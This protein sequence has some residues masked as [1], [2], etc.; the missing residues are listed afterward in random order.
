MQT[1]QLL[2]AITSISAQLLVF[3]AILHVLQKHIRSSVARESLW[4]TA[5]ILNCIS[6]LAVFAIPHLRL[7][8]EEPVDSLLIATDTAAFNRLGTAILIIWLTGM[9][10]TFGKLSLS[11]ASAARFV[12]RSSPADISR[13]GLAELWHEEI[14]KTPVPGRHAP[15]LLSSPHSTGPACW[16]FHKPVIILPPAILTYCPLPELRMMIRHELVHLSR[17][18]PIQ[19]FLQRLLEIAFWFHPSMWRFTE[20]LSKSR[21]MAC[22]EVC[23]ESAVDAKSYLRSLLTLSAFRQNG[24]RLPDEL[25]AFRK[26]RDWVGERAGEI[27]ARP[28]ENLQQSMLAPHLLA[29]VA[30]TM[31]TICMRLPLDQNTSREEMWSP[32][33]EWSARVLHAAGIDVRDY[34][35][36]RYRLDQNRH[37]NAVIPCDEKD[38]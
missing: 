19:L 11:L 2:E 35:P 9:L 14:Q 7:W 31:L 1:I 23:I 25:L 16:Q 30:C 17:Q 34:E 3:V 33:P 10:A 28:W 37:H 21:E 27:S 36:H 20:E 18:H 22:D 38:D 13:P 15:Q 29:I 6:T 26:G 4:T 5:L 8:P 24:M 12:S 32:W